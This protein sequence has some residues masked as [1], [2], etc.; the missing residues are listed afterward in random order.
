MAGVRVVSDHPLVAR[1]LRTGYH[2]RYK[3]VRCPDCQQDYY[4][5]ERMYEMDGDMVCGGCMK[6]R[7][8]DAYGIADLAHAFGIRRATVREIIDND[9]D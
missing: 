1:C 7:L 3:S 6:D 4:G 2:S 9:E 5:D 8:L